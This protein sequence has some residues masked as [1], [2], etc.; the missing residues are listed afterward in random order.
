MDN[1][2][3][4]MK[5]CRIDAVYCP[6]CKNKVSK[7]TYYNHYST[8]FNRV[9]QTWQQV[10]SEEK[11]VK[12]PDFDFQREEVIA[13]VEA[14]SVYVGYSDVLQVNDNHLEPYVLQANDDYHVVLY[15]LMIIHWSYTLEP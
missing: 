12:E 4:S 8:Y 15:N 13:E 7:S 11:S 2:T 6:H 3:S 1:F 9:S 10:S 5:I 14:L